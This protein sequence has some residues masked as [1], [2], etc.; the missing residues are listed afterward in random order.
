MGSELHIE[1]RSA[2]SGGGAGIAEAEWLDFVRVSPDFEF[3]DRLTAGSPTGDEIDGAGP[4]GW[5][6]GH[7]VVAAVPFRWSNGCV[8]VAFTD[9]HSV[10]GA[11][12]VAAVFGATVVD[13][14]GN[15]YEAPEPDWQFPDAEQPRPDPVAMDAPSFDSPPE[16]DEL[17]F[18]FDGGPTFWDRVRERLGR[19]SL[20]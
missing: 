3:R 14:D 12:L 4:F 2:G 6:T 20:R 9:E 11:L 17:A 1:R 15:V 7:P 18:D 8:I 5:W 13:D 16:R 10:T 19:R